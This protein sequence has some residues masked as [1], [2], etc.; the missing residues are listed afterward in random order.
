VRGERAVLFMDPPLGPG[1]APDP[2]VPP[3]E[4]IQVNHT[5]SSEE[6]KNLYFHPPE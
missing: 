3:E 4:K 2:A 1:A 6:E 5:S